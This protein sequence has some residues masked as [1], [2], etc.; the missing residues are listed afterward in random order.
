MGK[1]EFDAEKHEYTWEGQKI[2][3][4]SDILAPLSAERYGE[5]N[6][7]VLQ[8]AAARGTAVHEIC[9]A[10]DY[11]LDPE[12]EPGLEGY[13]QAYSDFLRDYFPKWELIEQIVYYR[14]DGDVYT[15]PPLFCGTVDRYGTIDDKPAVLDIKTY[16]SL[17]TDS[18]ISASCQTAMY[19]TAIFSA[20]PIEDLHKAEE[21]RRYLLHLKKD[22]SYRLVDL[23]KFDIERDFD[24]AETTWMLRILRQEIDKARKG[25]KGGKNG[26]A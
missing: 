13:A 24:S 21:T 6:P 22:G 2:P 8:Q 26:K 11:G 17:T 18:M 5:I 4:V 1:I 15:A 25:K 10:M 19:R 23:N 3:S 9:E 7:A 12:I 14:V 20:V 16:A